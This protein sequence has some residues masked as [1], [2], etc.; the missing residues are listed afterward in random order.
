MMVLIPVNCWKKGIRTATQGQAGGQ[1]Q[2]WPSKLAGLNRIAAA[3]PWQSR[4]CLSV[5]KVTACA[6]GRA[7]HVLQLS[8]FMPAEACNSMCR[9]PGV[10]P[11]SS[12]SSAAEI[13]TRQQVALSGQPEGLGPSTTAAAN[14]T[15][16]MQVHREGFRVT[17]RLRGPYGD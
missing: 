11:A 13:G 7:E 5:S 8:L 16:T 2:R 15:P 6:R 1:Q 14:R 10:G 17:E 9:L 12:C 4:Q 3:A